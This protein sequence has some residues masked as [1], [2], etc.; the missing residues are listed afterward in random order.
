M[1]LFPI[2]PSFAA[3]AAMS[4]AVW[5]APLAVLSKDLAGF[6]GLLVANASE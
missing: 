4:F 1:A 3:A 6:W 5:A 2:V